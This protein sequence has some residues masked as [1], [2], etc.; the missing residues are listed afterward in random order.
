VP[1]SKI[2]SIIGKS[3]QVVRSI[4]AQSGAKIQ[5]SG[6]P[7]TTSDGPP[8]DQ[9][10]NVQ[11][12]NGQSIAAAV[13]ILLGLL[14]PSSTPY[15]F[16]PQLASSYWP[17]API[18]QVASIRPDQFEIRFALRPAAVSK[19]IGK[20]GQGIQSLCKQTHVN[21]IFDKQTQQSIGG[22][23]G[24]IGTIR[25][26]VGNIQ[27]AVEVLISA[28][29]GTPTTDG[30][31]DAKSQNARFLLLVPTPLVGFLLGTKGAKMKETKA[32]SKAQIS[33]T[34]RTD[35]IWDHSTGVALQ[36]TVIEGTCEQVTIA[37]KSIVAQL[38]E[39]RPGSK[40]RREEQPT[41]VGG[42]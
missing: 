22:A 6:R 21:L 25:G 34:G 24:Q 20:G 16:G 7:E 42:S 30:P 4:Y 33:I 32:Q 28:L 11:G 18:P 14:F 8:V 19:I 15:S 1:S 5:I 36:A 35:A 13:R 3:G 12:R 10:V 2:G 40:R 41:Q 26:E 23:P 29:F 31:D 9:E 27:S 39:A 17:P 37:V 38:D